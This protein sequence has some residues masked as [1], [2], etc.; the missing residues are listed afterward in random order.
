[1]DAYTCRI[2][3]FLKSILNLGDVYKFKS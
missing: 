1:M 3:S 2:I